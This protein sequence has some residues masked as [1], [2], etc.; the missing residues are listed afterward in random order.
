MPLNICTIQ[1]MYVHISKY[2]HPTKPTS[3]AAMVG[4]VHILTY[5]FILRFVCICLGWASLHVAI[6]VQQNC[7]HQ[8]FEYAY[9]PPHCAVELICFICRLDLPTAAVTKWSLLHIYIHMKPYYTYIQV[10]LIQKTQQFTM[11]FI[12]K[13]LAVSGN[14]IGYPDISFS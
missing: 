3:L 6:R 12:F 11:R 2:K 10:C 14:P 4:F 7:L 8:S 13:L 5:I 1:Y 9:K